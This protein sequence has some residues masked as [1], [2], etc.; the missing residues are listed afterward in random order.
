LHVHGQLPLEH[1]LLS[2]KGIEG[3]IKG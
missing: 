1:L 2:W 3:K